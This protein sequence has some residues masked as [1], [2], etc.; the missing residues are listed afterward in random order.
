VE[1]PSNFSTGDRPTWELYSQCIHC[2]LCLRQCPTYRVLGLEA[3]S[4][5]GRIYQILQVDSGRLPIGDSFALHMDRCLGCRACETACPSGVE[6]GRIFERART[7]IQANYKRPFLERK[8][9]DYAYRNVLQRFSSLRR[10]ARIL[11]FYQR[12]GLQGMVRATGILRLLGLKEVEQLAPRIDDHFFF[13]E[14]GARFPATGE[15]R[16]RV[17][18]LAGCIASVAFSELN[19]A[20]IRVL[21]ANGIEVF[22]PP[23][24]RCCG[25]LHAHAGYRKEA[26]DL[27]RTNIRA[28]LDYKCDAIVTNTAGCGAAMKEYD[29]LLAESSR[30][31]ARA[32]LFAAKVRDVTEY[33]AEVGLLPP[34]T[35]IHE[36]VTFQDS[37]HLAHGQKVR[38]Q[39]RELLKAVGVELVEMP[40]ADQ[41]C[42]SAGTYNVTQNELSMEILKLKMDDVASIPVDV[43]ATSNVGCIM[44]LKAGVQQRGLQREVVHVINLLDRAYAKP[45]ESRKRRKRHKQPSR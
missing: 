20:T 6:Y 37:C 24:Q 39:P 45:V 3:D 21:N 43:I 42:G 9:R 14:I 34:V 2:G 17:A 11:R 19:R 26:R 1:T 23:H 36:R 18:L 44:Q 35:P 40:R 10:W 32:Q 4:P 33:L 7:E 8:L 27:A 38:N 22:V 13:E 31:A 28:I 41:C 30:Y 15:L 5:R 29:D 16:G 12:S 25:A